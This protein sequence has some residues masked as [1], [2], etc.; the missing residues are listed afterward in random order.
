MQKQ[1]EEA[2]K[3]EDELMRLQNQLF[4][5]FIQR[6]SVPQGKHRAGFAVEQVELEVRVQPPQPS[7]SRRQ[8]H[9]G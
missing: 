8:L 7:K 1:A 4:K 6:F 3:R 2:R 5:A 9:R